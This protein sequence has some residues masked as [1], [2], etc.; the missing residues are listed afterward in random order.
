MLLDLERA[1]VRL[2]RRRTKVQDPLNDGPLNQLYRR[3]VIRMS[4]TV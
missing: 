1:T 3:T 4:V 2:S